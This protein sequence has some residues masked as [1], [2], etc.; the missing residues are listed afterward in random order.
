MKK[1]LLVSS[2]AFLMS[3]CCPDEALPDL[4]VDTCNY[5]A[6]LSQ[7][8]T[9]D[10]GTTISIGVR[11]INYADGQ[12][13]CGTQSA[14]ENAHQLGLFR[15][16]ESSEQFELVGS[17]NYLVSAIK[18]NQGFDDDPPVT[19]NVPGEYYVG[20]FCD[21]NNVVLERSETNNDLAAEENVSAGR[22]KSSYK[23]IVIRSNPEF[24]ARVKKGEVIPFVEFPDRPNLISF[25]VK[26]LNE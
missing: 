26:K 17:A 16:N 7:G 13:E 18:S 20:D 6:D 25:W 8:N 4:I 23:T 3:S 24:E 9:F 1:I 12:S 21:I 14:D 22:L 2:L 15:K 10:I 5:L 19:L 11:I